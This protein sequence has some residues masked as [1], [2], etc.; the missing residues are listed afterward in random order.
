MA[1]KKQLVVKKDTNKLETM[2]SLQLENKQLS[3]EKS[4]YFDEVQR[5]KKPKKYYIRKVSF[6]SIIGGILVSGIIS[7][8]LMIPIF[9]VVLMNWFGKSDWE[10]G[11]EGKPYYKWTH[12]F[13]VEVLAEEDDLVEAEEED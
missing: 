13:S 8:I 1:K 6:K 3:S 7:I 9:N 2:K 10:N 4:F 5:L 11:K 12:L